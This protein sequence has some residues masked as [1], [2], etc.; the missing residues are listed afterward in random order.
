MRVLLDEI[1]ATLNCGIYMPALISILA[2]P[3]ACGAIEYPGEKNTKRF[4]KWFDHYVR[5]D[6]PPEHGWFNGDVVWKV[7]NA[8][9]HETSLQLDGQQYD[10]VWF[11]PDDQRPNHMNI[12]DNRHSRSEY[13]KRA[14][15]VHLR[16][17][18]NEVA[19]GVNKWLNEI[20]N[21]ACSDRQKRLDR[22]IQ[23]RPQGW[24]GSGIRLPI[25]C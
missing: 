23:F 20:E 2:L 9:L 8:I 11:C 18:F 6:C 13:G 17:F 24:I 21:D 16:E 10:E 22:M 5:G 14:L 15:Q 4:I 3:D 1:E 12:T 25:I 19:A 7:R